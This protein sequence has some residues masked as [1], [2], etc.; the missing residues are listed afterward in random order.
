[1]LLELTVSLFFLNSIFILKTEMNFSTENEDSILQISGSEGYLYLRKSACCILRDEML[2]L[3]L[4]NFKIKFKKYNGYQ[5]NA[6]QGSKEKDHSLF[7]RN[8]KR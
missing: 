1:M 3:V 5:G 7:K 4:Q 2:Q 6:G 8:P